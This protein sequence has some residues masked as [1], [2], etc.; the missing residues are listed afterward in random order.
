MLTEWLL[1]RLIDKEIIMKMVAIVVKHQVEN[2][3]DKTISAM[4]FQYSKHFFP[5]VEV[6]SSATAAALLKMSDSDKEKLTGCHPQSSEVEMEDAYVLEH[7]E[8]KVDLFRITTRDNKMFR[9][10]QRESIDSKEW[11]PSPS[12]SPFETDRKRVKDSFLFHV[13]YTLRKDF[14]KLNANT[15]IHQEWVDID[16][17]RALLDKLED[18]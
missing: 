15:K 14:V 18:V 8:E 7:W 1:R 5:T 9:V 12:A 3:V 11:K 2:E 10:E 17:D 6:I 13:C 4:Q 16:P